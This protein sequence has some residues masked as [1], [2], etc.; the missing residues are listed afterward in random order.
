[1]PL[2]GTAFLALWNDIARNREREYED[3]HTLE[4]VPERVAVD[5][6]IGAR[7]YVNRARD[8]HRY[9]TL[10]DVKS[11]DVFESAEYRDLV[12]RPTPRSEAMRPDF[13]NFL[14]APCTLVA[15][16]G[17]GIG[18][19]IATLCVPRSV[20]EQALRLQMQ[21]AL[22]TH[23]VNAAHIGRRTESSA[24]SPLPAN[25]MSERKFEHIMLIEATNLES[26]TIALEA[27][28][29][30]LDLDSLPRD[31]GNDIY[32]LAFVFPAAG[33]DER[34]RHRRESWNSSRGS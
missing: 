20:T 30:A 32:D 25:S 21:L 31:F 3:W 5:G 24:P 8:E 26:A 34:R 29:R 23:S 10:Y 4:H 16:E 9:F 22:S 19:A 14:R 18:A 15:S 11:L 12:D 7:R 33:D 17:A 13:A 6:F 28:K 1:M 2:A 27:V